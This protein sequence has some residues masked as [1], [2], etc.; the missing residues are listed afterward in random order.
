V[1]SIKVAVGDQVNEGDVVIILESMKM[2]TEVRAST[3]GSIKSIQVQEGQNV[4]TGDT[5]LVIG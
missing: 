2:E 5:L 1:F 3:G 4:K